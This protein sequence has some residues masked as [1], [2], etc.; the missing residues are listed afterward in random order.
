MTQMVVAL[1]ANLTEPAAFISSA[2]D[3]LALRFTLVKRSSVYRSRPVGGPDQPDYLNAVAIIDSPDSPSD[4]LRVLHEIENSAGR[5]R[6]VRW[7]PRTLD[8]DLIAAEN[9]Q[10][11]DPE[12]LIPHPRAHERAFVLLPWAEIDPD[13]ELSGYGPIAELVKSIDVTGVERL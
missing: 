6:T 13:A 3:E 7:G 4:V 2:F 8:L 5:E 9:F 10:S 12:C 11:E 1:G